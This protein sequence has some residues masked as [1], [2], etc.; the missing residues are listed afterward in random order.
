[1]PRTSYNLQEKVARQFR[2]EAEKVAKDI[3]SYL[4]QA[5]D[6]QEIDVEEE[7]TLWWT[8]GITAEQASELFA[9]GMEVDEIMDQRFPNRRFMIT[10][11]RPDP[12]MQVSYAERMQKLTEEKE[13]GPSKA[14]EP[15]ALPNVH[16][17][18]GGELQSTVEPY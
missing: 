18:S 1:M 11:T 17:E 8:E 4:G 5:T 3:A 6:S 12:G 13:W 2:T 7:L 15:G 14:R 16:N 10:H 9:Q